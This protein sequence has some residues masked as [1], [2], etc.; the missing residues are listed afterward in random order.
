MC[1]KLERCTVAGVALAQH[2]LRIDGDDCGLLQCGK[3]S[4]AGVGSF[5]IAEIENRQTNVNLKAALALSA[6]C[7]ISKACDLQG[8]D[9]TLNSGESQC[10]C[11]RIKPRARHP[12]VQSLIECAARHLRFSERFSRKL[13][14]GTRKD[15]AIGLL[16]AQSEHPNELLALLGCCESCPREFCRGIRQEGVLTRLLDG[17]EIAALRHAPGE[18]RACIGRCMNLL[19]ILQR[20]LG[21]HSLDPGPTRVCCQAEYVG[22]GA[23]VGLLLQAARQVAS[24]GP[25]Q[26]IDQ[27]DRKLAVYFHR[28][29]R[30]EPLEREQ[31]VRSAPNLARLGLRRR[32]RGEQ[33]LQSRIRAERDAHRIVGSKRCGEQLVR[34][35][36]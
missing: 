26:Q 10:A 23:H 8:I 36:L 1:S 15:Q 20:L 30:G 4:R 28:A 9:R 31:G 7:G 32:I 6:R 21:A 22:R 19:G 14:Q 5:G 24:S 16:S 29:V 18:C 13:G 34:L 27:R 33:T 17:R 2:R 35:Q 11:R 12:N 3:V 25:L